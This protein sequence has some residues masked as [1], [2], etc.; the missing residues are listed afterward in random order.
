MSTLIGILAVVYPAEWELPIALFFLLLFSKNQVWLLVVSCILGVLRACSFLIGV[1]SPF[2]DD[3][4][5]TFEVGIKSETMCCSFGSVEK[6]DGLKPPGELRVRL[7]K[8]F[9]PGDFLH[10]QASLKPLGTFEI[11]G[12]GQEFRRSVT[13]RLRWSEP[14]QL[15]HKQFQFSENIRRTILDLAATE[16]EPLG[17]LRRTLIVGDMTGLSPR[18]WSALNYLGLSHA[19]VISGSHL[20]ILI[21]VIG[22]VLHSIFRFFRMRYFYLFRLCLLGSIAIFYIICNPDASLDRA[23]AGFVFVSLLGIIIPAI[24]RYPSSEKLSIIGF[25][26]LVAE[27]QLAFSASYALSFGATWAILR[28]SKWSRLRWL[29]P[30]FTLVP[31]CGI[32]RFLIHPF[33][34]L[35]NILFLPL[36]FFGVVPLALGSIFVP[37][38]N[39]MANA[40]TQFF[41]EGLQSLSTEL[42]YFSW[43]SHSAPVLSG[44]VLMMVVWLLAAQ[45]RFSVRLTS[46]ILAVGSMQL[47]AFVPGLAESARELSVEVLDVGQGDAMLLRM[48]DLQIVIDGGAVSHQLEKSVLDRFRNRVD[49]WVLTHFDRDHVSNFFDQKYFF[50][51]ARIWVP[52]FDHSDFG[53]WARS[54]HTESASQ[55]Q[56]E[57]C[58]THYCLTA[59]VDPIRARSQDRVRNQDSIVLLLRT[60]QT[61]DLL[62]IFMGDLF[63]DG[64]E[65]LLHDLQKSGYGGRNSIPLLKAGHHGSKTSS[66][67]RFLGALRPKL[68][69]ICSGRNN[70]YGHPHQEVLER[71]EVADSNFLSTASLG[72]FKVYFDF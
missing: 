26:L 32:F 31:I 64:E 5:H 43:K 38:L 35:V 33:S 57:L 53:H 52:R 67:K 54:A 36:F 41:F 50:D 58:S 48:E 6:L 39:A 18:V 21:L 51:A 34:P 62:A 13:H 40:A 27:P 44:F 3:K 47:Y 42:Q 2:I 17:S 1:A 29:S 30:Y 19:L 65:R 68:T 46:L 56:R 9:Q 7:P 55:T 25:L 72:N 15:V 71:L 23:F 49:L 66:S 69:V 28:S 22:F 20:T 24:H 70:S 45:I 12:I 37:S 11:P 60:R 4:I 63:R 61:K 8:E 16:F 14:P 10:G 59:W